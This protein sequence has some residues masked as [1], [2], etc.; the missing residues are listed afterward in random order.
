MPDAA[1]A[2][3]VAGGP[4]DD[5]DGIVESE[6]RCAWRGPPEDDLVWRGM[7]RAEVRRNFDMRV[8]VPDG[9]SHAR[10]RAARSAP[11]RNSL[12]GDRDVRY[13]RDPRQTVDVYS[14]VPDGPIVVFFHGGAWRY[15]SKDAFAFIAEPLVAEGIT[16]VV[17]GYDLIPQIT[18][19]RMMSQAR[20]AVTWVCREFSPAGERRVVLAGHSAGAQLAGMALAHDYRKYGLARSPAHGALLISGAYDMEPH[21]YHDRYLDMCLDDVLIQDS[22]PLRNPPL[23]AGV[24]M[25]IA[26]GAKETP[27]FIRQAEDFHR[28]C[29][30]RGHHATLLLVADD[31]HFSVANRLGERSHPLTSS[32]IALAR[33]DK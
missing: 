13:G 9:E 12:P 23:D 28:M 17:A 26:A 18:L 3:P 7:T 4:T 8:A 19:R 30:A 11:L 24:D 15:Q 2:C 31:H 22:S 29:V 25:I 16:V 14:G 10:A 21:R 1:D 20:E 6:V 27:G 33:G 32:L 5:V